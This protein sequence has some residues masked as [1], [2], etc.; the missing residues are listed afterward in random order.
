MTE[1][2]VYMSLVHAYVFEVAPDATKRDVVAAIEAL[3]QVKPRKVTIVR[4][5]P[6]AFVARMRNRRGTKTGMKKAYVFL[7]KGDKLEIK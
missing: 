2:A 7:A 5:Q 1:K 3:Y 4:K 6:R